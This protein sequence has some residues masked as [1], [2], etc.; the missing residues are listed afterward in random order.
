MVFYSIIRE[1]KNIGGLD[2]VGVEVGD[3]IMKRVRS[4]LSAVRGRERAAELSECGIHINDADQPWWTP[5]TAYDNPKAQQARIREFVNHTRYCEAEVPVFVGHSLFFKGFYSKRISKALA[6]NRPDLAECMRKHRLSNG[7]LLA[8]TVKY[9]EDSF[10]YVTGAND[11]IIV[12]SDV[13]FGGGFT[14]MKSAGEAAADEGDESSGDEM[15]DFIG[16]F[17]DKHKSNKQKRGDLSIAS[18]IKSNYTADIKKGGNA[19]SSLN[20]QV[21]NLKDSIFKKLF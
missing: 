8:V 1:I 20:S 9:W 4:E 2:T 19:L 17:S 14:H 6:L 7:T 3:G 15:E 13:I 12:D 10:D 21:K 18:K 11:G 5:M 16:A